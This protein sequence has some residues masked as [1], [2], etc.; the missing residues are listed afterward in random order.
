MSRPSIPKRLRAQCFALA[1]GKCEHCGSKLDP[2][3]WDCD[4]VDPHHYVKCH[5]IENLQAL[6]K[7]CHAAKTA[8][9]VHG[10]AWV[11]HMRMETGQQARRARRK[12]EGKQ[13]L[14]QNKGFDKGLR[15]RLDGTVE[16]RT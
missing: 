4:H 3:A 5:D 10:I 12:A 15:K 1:N 16:K 14:I 2:K 9:D 8:M 11:R 7:P 13:P 6:C